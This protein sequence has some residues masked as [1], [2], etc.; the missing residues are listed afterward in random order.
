[1]AGGLAVLS[2][3]AQWGTKAGEPQTQGAGGFRLS[4]PLQVVLN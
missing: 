3:G 4:E 1:L 2:R